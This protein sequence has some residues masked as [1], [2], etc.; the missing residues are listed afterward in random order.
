MESPPYHDLLEGGAKVWNEWR[1]QNPT[2]K[3][4]FLGAN[5]HGAN[6]KGA[7]L[8]G[9][10]LQDT[11]GLTQEQIEQALG[12]ETNT[13]PRDLRRPMEWR[14]PARAGNHRGAANDTVAAEDQ[15]GFAHYVEAFAQLIDSP[16]TKPPLTIGIYGSWGMG[17]SF[18]L[19]NIEWKL[20]D[21]MFKNRPLSPGAAPRP[22]VH[23]VHFNAWEYSAAEVI[24]PGLVR[25]IMDTFEETWSRPRRFF[26]KFWRNAR[27]QTRRFRGHLLLTALIL[28]AIFLVAIWQLG[29]DAKDA[30]TWIDSAIA[31]GGAITVLAIGGLVKLVTDTLANPL[32][33]Y[34]TALTEGEQPVESAEARPS[35]MKTSQAQTQ[36]TST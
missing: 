3:P 23:V 6:L 5:L 11:R 33:Q 34:V 14:S 19:K 15:L 12:D 36:D 30:T 29:T 31:L 32:G 7:N 18:L 26:T 22:K 13:L 35:D 27:R 25:K 2:A 9:V 28:A 17:K 1:Q 10:S 21:E 16:D 8:K 4:A 20:R 24:W